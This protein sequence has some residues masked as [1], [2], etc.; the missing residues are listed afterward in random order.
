[1]YPKTKNKLTNTNTM[2]KKNHIN[3][4]PNERTK[5]ATK[6]QNETK[7]TEEEKNFIIK[8]L[9]SSIKT[10]HRTIKTHQLQNNYDVA[11]IFANKL[12]ELQNLRHKLTNANNM[13]LYK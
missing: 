6:P 11:D 2:F 10:L 5:M 8:S 9:D 13:E 3:K 1:M 4:Q 12:N 7:I